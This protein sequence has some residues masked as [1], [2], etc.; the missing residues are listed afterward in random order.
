MC[1]ASV[2]VP[3]RMGSRCWKPVLSWPILT[4]LGAL[5]SLGA[6]A[7]R[8]KRTSEVDVELSVNE[9]SLCAAWAASASEYYGES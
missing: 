7:A 8:E 9:S 6:S 3:C 4:V 1:V 2:G 5:L